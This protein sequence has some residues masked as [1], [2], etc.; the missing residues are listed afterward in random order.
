MNTKRTL[1]KTGNIL[2]GALGLSSLLVGCNKEKDCDCTL[3]ATYSYTYYGQ[4]FEQE[5]ETEIEMTTKGSCEDA[6][7]EA[8]GDYEDLDDFEVDCEE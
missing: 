8:A 2:L 4:T 3:T 6:E 5:L 7:F 1:R